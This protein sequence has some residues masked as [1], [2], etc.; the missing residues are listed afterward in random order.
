MDKHAEFSTTYLINVHHCAHRSR[1]V[2]RGVLHTETGEIE[3]DDLLVQQRAAF[4]RLEL[5]ENVEVFEC[6][7]EG[8]ARY[9]C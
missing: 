1:K 2:G 4:G 3:N 9:K 5:F 8:C 7:R 6:L